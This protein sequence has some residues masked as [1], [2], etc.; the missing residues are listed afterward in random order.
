MPLPEAQDAATM[1]L[2]CLTQD[3]D[4]SAFDFSQKPPRIAG[5]EWGRCLGRGAFGQVWSAR[6]SA[7]GQ[8][9][10]VKLFRALERPAQLQRELDRL[11]SLGQHPHVVSILDAG[12]DHDPPYLITALYQ[13]TLGA[14][15]QQRR[16]TGLEKLAKDW[17]LSVASALEFMH[18]CGVLHCDLKPDN[19]LLDQ[20]GSL[21][22][23]DFGQAVLLQEQNVRLGTFFFMPPE[24]VRG[25]P[26]DQGWD[27][28]ALG[29]TFYYVLSGQLPRADR[30]SLKKLSLCGQPQEKLDTYH[31]LLLS[32]P[33]VPLRSLNSK[34]PAW[35]SEC[36][37]GCLQLDGE[38]RTR[39]ASILVQTLRRARSSGGTNSLL[40]RWDR[41]RSRAGSNPEAVKALGLLLGLMSVVISLLC[42]YAVPE[43]YIIWFPAMGGLMAIS[44]LSVLRVR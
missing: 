38:Q 3:F 10:A 6:R 39:G 43:F 29:A 26:P 14:L 42:W 18:R 33:L 27:L 5:L 11:V 24:Q 13:G 16:F 12:L 25:E 4:P 19:L 31:R 30:E 37:E 8:Q 17:M 28:Y 35:L 20:E 15:A 36:I 40:M 7:T 23:A 44:I 1:D 34:V 21:R 2:S 22:V 9:V 32:T 41:E